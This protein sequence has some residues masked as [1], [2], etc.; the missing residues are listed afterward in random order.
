MWSHVL[1]LLSIKDELQREFYAAM[2]KNENWSV[3]TLRERKKSML[4]ERTIISKKPDAT[5]KNEINELTEEK[6]M[7]LDM[8]YRDPYMLDFFG[9]KDTYSEKGFGKCYP[10]SIGKIYFGNGFRFSFFSPSKTFCP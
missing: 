6:K 10:C 8:L 4:Y 7:S 5:I 2:C 3:R 1:V 9:L